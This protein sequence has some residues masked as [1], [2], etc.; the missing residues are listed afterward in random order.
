[1]KIINLDYLSANPLAPEVREAM[2]EAMGS[3]MGNPSSPHQLG[4]R[5]A[6]ALSKA[7]QSVADLVNADSSKEIIFTSGG[8]ESV[9]LAIKGVAW[10]KQGKGRHII[11]SNI[12][13][14]SVQKCLKRLRM[15]D[16]TVTS[17][18][19]DERGMVNPDDVAG[20][21]TDETILVTI[22]HGNNEIGSLQPIR[23]IG[24]ITREKKIAFHT[25]AV[26]SAGVV[27]V[28]VQDLGVNLLSLSANQFYGP[29]GVGA[30]YLKKGTGLWPLLDGG[31]QENN[32]RAG[33]ENILGIIG[34]GVASDLAKRD[35]EKR[36]AHSL[37]IKKRLT[38]GLNEKISEIY[39]NGH[40]EKS[41]PNLVSTSI[42]YI[43][44]EGIVLMLDEENIIGATRSACASGAL[45]ASHVL[46]SIGRDFA[47]AQ[48]TLVF[49][50]G[51]GV[52]EEDI[53][54]TLDVLADSISTLRNMSPLYRKRNQS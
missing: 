26:A 12:E 51:D 10:A 37:K 49:T 11:T 27:P 45:Q 46:L 5:A 22:M 39:I 8:T 31:M 52:E 48:G 23:E 14:T 2:I 50:F 20:A 54:K 29:S 13:H 17:V 21:I 15:S 33:T 38:A 41:L 42:K 35:M 25:D 28:D 43:E 16:Y 4:D 1:M 24:Q 53:D 19:V 6:D 32:K 30:L 36:I 7:R 34:M 44:G 18:P 47:E 9:N 40:P 3:S